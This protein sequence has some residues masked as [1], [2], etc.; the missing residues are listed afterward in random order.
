MWDDAFPGTASGAV[1]DIIVTATVAPT[2]NMS[3]SAGVIDLGN[4]VAGAP[5]SGN[6][7]IEIGTNAVS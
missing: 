7:N 3:I 6:L 2:L 5:S 4:L 1:T